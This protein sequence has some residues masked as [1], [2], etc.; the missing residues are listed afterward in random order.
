MTIEFE[1]VM[2]G[3][4]FR[5]FGRNLSLPGCK[6]IVTFI[7]PNRSS[8]H[9]AVVVKAEPYVLTVQAPFDLEAGTHYQ[10]MV[11][12]GAGGA[13]GNSLAE[14]RLFA[15]KKA[16]ILFLYKYLGAVILFF[17]KMSIMCERILD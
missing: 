4:V 15:V 1:E 8:R 14:E 12:N 3:Y 13:Y 10:V 6:P 16:K 9:Q 2:P 7:H 5:I 17:I 11:N